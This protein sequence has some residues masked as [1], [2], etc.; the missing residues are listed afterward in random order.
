MR[1]H[2]LKVF[3]ATAAVIL[4]GAS[5]ADAC[6]WFHG[7]YFCGYR[8]FGWFAARPVYPVAYAPPVGFAN[9]CCNPCGGGA[10]IGGNC[11]SACSTCANYAPTTDEPVPEPT[12]SNGDTSIPPD[13]FR[14]DYNTRREPT[15]AEP[16][17]H[18]P[19]DNE[20][21]GPA[22][23]GWRGSDRP[24]RPADAEPTEPGLPEAP[25]VVPD[26]L[27]PEPT[28]PVDPFNPLPDLDDDGGDVIRNIRPLSVPAPAITVIPAVRTR[29][30]S[31][32][33]G[34][35]GLDVPSIA[36]ANAGWIPVRHDSRV[37]SS[38]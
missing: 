4:S 15:R 13:D 9:P 17:A 10:C 36:D 33:E 37:V 6:W 25:P 27:I 18:E 22:A 32:P 8:P 30:A 11:G 20:N 35:S 38:R 1:T 26:A 3:V 23:G 28:D 2:A 5:S 31:R 12:D 34:F 29:L 21:L 7:G 16:P 19:D 24:V 14:G